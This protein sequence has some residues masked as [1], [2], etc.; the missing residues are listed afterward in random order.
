[1]QEEPCGSVSF[2]KSF[3][4]QCSFSSPHPALANWQVMG[5]ANALVQSDDWAALIDDAK[6]RNCYLDVDSL[7]KEFIPKPSTYG[8]FS[9]EF[10]SASGLT[11]EPRYRPQES[12][13]NSRVGTPSEVEERSTLP[14]IS[15]LGSH[16]FLRRST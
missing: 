15:R 14:Y 3:S 11:P 16:R 12:Y 1:M 8:A 7:P 9:S 2:F 5:N 4:I 6:A 13:V 10:Y